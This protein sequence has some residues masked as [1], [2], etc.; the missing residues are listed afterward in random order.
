MTELQTIDF[1]GDAIH[2]TQD[3]E[4]KIW[5]PFRRVCDSLGLDPDSPAKRLK[6]NGWATT[7]IMTVVAGD[8]RL[9]EILCV[10]IR[11]LTMWLATIDVRRIAEH[12]QPKVSL[13][14]FS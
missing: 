6:R 14:H 9:R 3:E 11:T 5:I 2:A 7:V 1:H 10:D 4:G 12:L 8:S 13:Y